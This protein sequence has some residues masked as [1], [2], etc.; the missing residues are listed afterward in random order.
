[1]GLSIPVKHLALI[2]IGETSFYG[3]VPIR[4]KYILKVKFFS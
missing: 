2:T 1:M 3:P 4:R